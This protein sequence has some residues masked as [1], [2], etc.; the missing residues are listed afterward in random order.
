MSG[1]V[2]S[3]GWN[4]WAGRRLEADAAACRMP[5]SCERVSRPVWLASSNTKRDVAAD[6]NSSAETPRLKLVSAD[7]TGSGIWSRPKSAR[8]GF[9][10]GFAGLDIHFVMG[11]FVGIDFAVVIGV[12]G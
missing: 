9:V 3:I 12:E 6:R 7:A 1:E 4:G 11:D 5:C 2:W 8:A 10:V